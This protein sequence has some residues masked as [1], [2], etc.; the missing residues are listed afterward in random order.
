METGESEAET[1]VREMKEELNLDVTPMRLCW[2][3]VTPWGTLLAWW[4]ASIDPEA[5]PEPDLTEVEEYFWMN[6][7]EIHRAKN[8]LPSLP[9]LMDAISAREVNL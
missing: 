3:S 7:E 8:V 5:I 6:A 9:A 1:L 4:R 2:R